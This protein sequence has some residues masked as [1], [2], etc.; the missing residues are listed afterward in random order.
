VLPAP[1]PAR[2]R[3]SPRRP[4]ARAAGEPGEDERPLWRVVVLLHTSLAP[5]VAFVIGFAFLVARLVTGAAY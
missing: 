4:G 3:L 5:L 2:R 1:P